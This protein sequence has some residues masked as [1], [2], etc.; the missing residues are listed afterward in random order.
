MRL[1]MIKRRDPNGL[2]HG[3]FYLIKRKE[4]RLRLLMIKKKEGGPVAYYT[5]LFI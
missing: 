4:P 5:D 2:L 1:L 3:P